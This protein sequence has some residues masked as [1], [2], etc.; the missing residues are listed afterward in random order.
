MPDFLVLLFLCA[1]KHLVPLSY[2]CNA[3]SRDKK[4]TFFND[5]AFK[6]GVR[7]PVLQI[8]KTSTYESSSYWQTNEIESRSEYKQVFRSNH[9]R[10]KK[11]SRSTFAFLYC[12]IAKCFSLPS[13]ANIPFFLFSLAQNGRFSHQPDFAA[14]STDRVFDGAS[15]DPKL[16]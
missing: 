15:A 2:G 13:V 1:I 12:R 5:L 10:P 16:P 6:A 14:P 7:S 4:S 8:P 3:S 9:C 11:S